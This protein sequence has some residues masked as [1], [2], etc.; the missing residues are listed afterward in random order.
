MILSANRLSVLSASI[1]EFFGF[2]RVT[3]AIDAA[4]LPSDAK[5]PP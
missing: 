1:K 5:L 3:L 2:M 4:M